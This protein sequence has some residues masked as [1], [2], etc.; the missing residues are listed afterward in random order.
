MS[1]KSKVDIQQ[2]LT[3]LLIQYIEDDGLLP[4]QCQWE[5]SNLS[6][7]PYNF[8]TNQHYNGINILLLWGACHKQGFS[9][10]AWLTYKQAESLGGN[11]IKGSKSVRCVFYKQIMIDDDD[12]EDGKK[13]IPMLKTFNLFNLDQI[14]GIEKPEIEIKNPLKHDE[15]IDDFIGYGNAYSDHENVKISYTG[16]NAF[17]RPSTDEIVLPEI[18]RFNSGSAFGSTLAHEIAH[19][20][21]HKSRLDRDKNLFKTDIENYAFE[22]LVAEITSAIVCADFGLSGEHINH[23]SYLKGWLKALK[24]DK[25][26]IF[27]AAAA[28]SKAHQFM[29]DATSL[30]S[31]AA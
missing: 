19:S 6:G 20:T 23:A 29:T 3:N 24:N 27:K 1:K 26:Y 13:A 14:E 10:N 16:Q 7:L 22:E 21:G 4:W 9:S 15:I 25:T 18:S 12:A 28:A 2:E 17:Y 30:K 31:C 8:D 5:K 11:V